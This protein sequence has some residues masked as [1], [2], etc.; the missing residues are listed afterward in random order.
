VILDRWHNVSELLFLCLCNKLND[1]IFIA[2]NGKIVDLGSGQ[3][4]AYRVRIVSVFLCNCICDSCYERLI[5][6]YNRKG[7]QLSKLTL[8]WDQFVEK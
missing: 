6:V 8:L 7:L 1:R 5:L 3:S 2:L 4:Y